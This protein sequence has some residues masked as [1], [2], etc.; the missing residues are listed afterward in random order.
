MDDVIQ[1]ISTEVIKPSPATTS[2]S[3]TQTLKRFKLGGASLHQSLI[4]ASTL[5]YV[6]LTLFYPAK[7][8][9]L[10]NVGLERAQVLKQSLGQTLTKFY[11]LA[12]KI[13]LGLKDDICVYVEFDDDSGACYKEARVRCH[14]S[15]FLKRP[16]Y[17]LMDGF[18]PIGDNEDDEG[19]HVAKTQVNIFE[20]GGIAVS[21]LISQF[22]NEVVSLSDFLKDWAGGTKGFCCRNGQALR[23]DLGFNELDL[24]QRR[25]FNKGKQAVSGRFIFDSEAI[26]SLKAITVSSRVPNPTTIEAVSSLIW[27]CTMDSLRTKS[28]LESKACALLLSTKARRTVMALCGDESKTDLD[29]LVHRLR[30][31][32]TEGGNSWL[33][34]ES[35]DMDNLICYGWCASGIYEVDFGWGRPAWVTSTGSSLSNISGHQFL[36][37]VMLVET[38]WGDGIEAWVTL[39]EKS[40][41]DL[42]R[43]QELLTFSLASS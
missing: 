36:N 28:G 25:L 39:D 16:D 8:R 37:S 14:M 10:F 9:A 38:R 26:A 29:D 3:S 6:P 31:A 33:E 5:S 20:C 22:V 1:L 7:P 23:V 34:Y 43:N 24:M 32:I 42:V 21:V 41:V 19:F 11:P 17:K 18:L 2:P 13:R 15:R 30:G 40:M 27:K 12:G 4:C 35:E